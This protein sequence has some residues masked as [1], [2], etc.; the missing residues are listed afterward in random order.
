MPE[1]LDALSLAE[2]AQAMSGQG[3]GWLL[4]IA[5]DEGRMA[6]LAEEIAFFAPGIHILRLPA[7]DTLPYD[8]TSPN[9]EICATRMNTLASL[10]GQEAPKAPSIL[11]T[12]I[13]ASLQR[14]APRSSIAGAVFQA[15]I[16][17]EVVVDE[18]LEF[19]VRN[20]YSRT[21]TVMEPGEF[22]TR[23]G[24]VDIY[25]AGAESPV[26]LDF[27]GDTLESIRLFDPLT[28]ITTG[29]GQTLNLVPV[30]EVQLTSETTDR[31]RQAYRELFGAITDEDPL[32]AS[33]RE[34]RRHAGM[35]H[36]LPLFYDEMETVFDY[37]NEGIVTMD[38]QCLEARDDRLAQVEDYYQARVEAQKN[39]YGGAPS[40]K[41]IPPQRLFMD[42]TAWDQAIA[43]RPGGV[44]SPFSTPEAANV[45]DFA[46]RQGRNFAAER[47]QAEINVF[48]ALR[49]HV[50]E[51][52]QRGRRVVFAAFSMGSAER[53]ALLLDDHGIEGVQAVDHW[54]G[55]LA[56][57]TGVPAMV[58][59]GLEHGVETDDLAIIS[60][61]DVLGDRLARRKR[62]RRAEDFL[63]EQN[64]LSDGDLVV[65]VEHGVGRYMGL[66]TIEVGGSAHD[67]LELH[68]H[69][70]D[71][72]FLPAVNIELLSRYGSEDAGA[73]LDKLGGAAWQARKAKLKQHIRDMADQL[74]K[75]A[76]ERV[77][78]AAPKIERPEGLYEEFCA[79][80]PF[81]E[82]EDQLGAIE[83]IFGDLMRG[84]PMD[85]LVCGDVGFGKT[86]VAL[87]GAFAT[88][89]TGS[90]VAVVAPTTLLCR[91]HYKTFTDRFAGLP[92]KVRQ[93]SRLVN[94][95]EAT[96]TREGLSNGQ[97]DIVI[98]T[99]ALLGKKIAFMNL[100]LL[101]I[102]EEQHFGVV[103]KERL[104]QLRSDVHV[105]TL[106]ATPIPRTLQMAFSGVKELSLIATPP[107][108]RL[109]VRTFVMPFDGVVI[110]EAIMREHYR[111]G[112][113]FYVC[114]RIKDLPEVEEFLRQHVPEVKFVTAHG[115]MAPRQ[116][117]DVMEAFYDGAYDVLLSTT[118]VESGLDIPTANTLIVHRADH[119]GLSQL[120][121]LRGRIGRSK[122]RAYAYLTLP[123]RARPTEAAEK[124]LKVLQSLDSL[125]AGFT[126][127]SHDLDLRGAG[128]LLGEEQSGHIR[129]VGFELYNQMLEEALATARSGAAGEI[130]P[131]D[132]EWSPQI[133]LGAAVLI[134]DHFVADLD[135]R[136]G[137]YRRLAHLQD[138]A[139]IDAFAAE[140]IDRFG[141]LPE[142]V[143]N[144]LAIITIKRMCREANVAKI[145]AG[146][147]GASVTF[148]NDNFAN[149][150]GLVA[151]INENK[152]TA[153]LRPDHKLVFQRQWGEAADRLKGVNYL[154]RQL[155]KL[156]QLAP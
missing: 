71:K 94:T 21:G 81:E 146:P 153:K 79:R 96:A 28:Q 106:T 24:I 84:T 36:W 98:G 38:H 51:Q 62:T 29:T 26:R 123:A 68:Y 16:G 95:A 10:V 138:A 93:L 61:Q 142:E 121:Q 140:L 75:V 151:L 34:G 139:E 9:P 22:A 105:L 18:L 136:L 130:N 52:R 91:Q 120:Y 155:V 41:P 31:F 80:F 33:I 35:E 1:G 65:H 104:K 6:T 74:I 154:I 115:R 67:C 59:L 78:R 149:P 137:L 125:G 66:K 131:S 30:S 111:G 127:A 148:H 55:V 129:E 64:Q 45:I 83:D 77:L 72:L 25:P 135:V 17:V 86:E 49:G 102:D 20:G 46:G 82:T 143:N 152:G 14:L 56:L 39:P 141:T 112:Q 100:N 122:V 156:A 132:Q 92:V 57:E 128:N 89:M 3:G 11:L 101:V 113:C 69:G 99:H 108:D 110:R 7:W 88:V 53:M 5:R 147:G 76:A 27:F 144:L 50:N 13:N 12:T 63:T 8:R 2:L 119:F 87:R 90:Q 44:Y 114:P 37:V 40:Y 150:G 145:D 58:V 70:N 118:I 85:R 124:R 32:Y 4:H 133:N 19:L 126:L 42:V 23:G 107:V 134:P 48:D 116:L 15:G 73:N 97:V 117:E 54:P 60:E 103:H 109:A 43:A 47:A